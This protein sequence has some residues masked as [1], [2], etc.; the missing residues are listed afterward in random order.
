[1][2]KRGETLLEVLI[3]LTLVTV[4]AAAAASAI[5]SATKGLSLSKNYLIA[6]NLASEALEAVKNI[7]DTN[8]M[9]FP[10]NKEECWMNIKPIIP[11]VSDSNACGLPTYHPDG[12][13]D[14][15]I[16]LDLVDNKWTLTYGEGNTMEDPIHFMYGL[17]IENSKY[18]PI[19]NG[20]IANFY[21]GIRIIDMDNDS[22]TIQAI[23]K[24]NDGAVPYTVTGT[25][26]LTN[27]L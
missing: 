6:Q 1:M 5:I 27:Y 4:S 22:I 19:A 12:N 2:N 26:I 8:W 3:A 13:N 16:T 17:K 14:Y 21:R 7:R 10:I 23:V 9:N 11:G 15:S 20:E 18:I 24:W 25:E